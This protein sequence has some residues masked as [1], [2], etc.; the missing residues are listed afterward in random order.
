MIA[1]IPTS[2]FIV[3]RIIFRMVNL[4][5]RSTRC[6]HEIGYHTNT[7]LSEFSKVR[8]QRLLQYIVARSCRLIRER[9]SSQAMPTRLTNLAVPQHQ[10]MLSLAYIFLNRLFVSFNVI[11]K[12]PLMCACVF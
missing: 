9:G 5:N 7:F 3:K 6:Y 4:L 10:F 11:I 1:W 8:S 2:K 12:T